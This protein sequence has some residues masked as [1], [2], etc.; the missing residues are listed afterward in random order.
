MIFD[1]APAEWTDDEIRVGLAQVAQRREE[2]YGVA[3]TLA[4]ERDRRRALA[5]QVDDA[6]SSPAYWL[7]DDEPD[8]G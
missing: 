3:V 2:L 8:A 6:M 5:R 7:P 4:D 1:K